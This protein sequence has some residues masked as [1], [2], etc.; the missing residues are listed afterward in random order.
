MTFNDSI[1]SSIISSVHY[2]IKEFIEL[3][4]T[5]NFY[6]I[7]TNLFNINLL[8]TF[9]FIYLHMGNLVFFN[10]DIILYDAMNDKWL[11]SLVIQI[12]TWEEQ[13]KE[14]TKFIFYL[15]NCPRLEIKI[16][17]WC[18]DKFY[19]TCIIWMILSFKQKEHF[20]WLRQISFAR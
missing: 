12:F 5:R 20:I 8:Y 13:N 7:K 2:W 4:I 14:T 17:E 16:N 11:P 1:I 15:T 6:L 9:T 3:F 10:F 18:F 19:E